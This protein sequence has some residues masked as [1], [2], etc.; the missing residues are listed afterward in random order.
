MI[1]Q[2]W[3]DNH[4]WDWDIFWT[5]YQEAC[6]TGGMGQSAFDWLVGVA[7]DVPPQMTRHFDKMI[8]AIAVAQAKAEADGTAVPL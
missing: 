7:P 3:L 4:W 2:R 6:S 8:D 5:I 1:N